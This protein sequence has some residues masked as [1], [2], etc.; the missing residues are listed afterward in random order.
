ML[1]FAFRNKLDDNDYAVK[2]IF[3]NP[4]NDRL[5]I[6]I[7]REAKLFAKLNHEHVVRYYSAWIEAIPVKQNLSSTIT[8]GSFI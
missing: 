2:R 7:K 4:K 6:K 8:D 3:L 1:N 5:N